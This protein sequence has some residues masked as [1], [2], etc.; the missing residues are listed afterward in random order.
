MIQ[1]Y[2]Q[3]LC[4]ELETYIMVQYFS[5]SKH[6]LELSSIT[7]IVYFQTKQVILILGTS[8]Q[9]CLDLV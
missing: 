7:H 4:L 8:T 9:V 6:I 3:R 5:E 1:L 2:S